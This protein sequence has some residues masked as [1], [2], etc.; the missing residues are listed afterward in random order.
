MTAAQIQLKE[1]RWERGGGRFGK[2]LAFQ[3]KVKTQQTRLKPGGISAQKFYHSDF[4]AF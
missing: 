2:L 4:Y 3:L 1:A